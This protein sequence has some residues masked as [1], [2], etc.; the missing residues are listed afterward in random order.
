MGSANAFVFAAAALAQSTGADLTG[1]ISGT[2][3]VQKTQANVSRRLE[4]KCC[5]HHAAIP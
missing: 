1:T 2:V 5:A 4:R 3:E